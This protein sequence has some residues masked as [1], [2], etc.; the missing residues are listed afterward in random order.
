M[1]AFGPVLLTLA[2]AFYLAFELTETTVRNELDRLAI[3]QL[4][5]ETRQLREV[6]EQTKSGLE[7]LALTP[8]V[9][10]GS[11]SA[12]TPQL[13]LWAGTFPY[14]VEALYYNTVD[15]DVYGSDDSSFNVRDRYYY[16]QIQNGETVITKVI[17]SRASGEHIILVL[18]PVFSVATKERIGAMGATIQ[19]RHLLAKVSTI[20]PGF[21][22]EVLLLDEAGHP[23]LGRK[24]RS[25]G[26]VTDA[27]TISVLKSIGSEASGKKSIQLAKVKGT[28]YFQTIADT[29]WRLVFVYSDAEVFFTRRLV[30]NTLLLFLGASL[31]FILLAVFRVKKDIT[32]PM[33]ALAAS[34]ERW[35]S[36]V[37]HAPFYIQT[38]DSQGTILF[39]NQVL[40]GLDRSKVIGSSIY[41]YSGPA[42]STVMREAVAA[43]FQ[44]GKPQT[45]ELEASGPHGGKA[46]YTCTVGAIREQDRITKAVVIAYDIS[47]LKQAQE[48]LRLHSLVL[49]N[50]A[51]G[52]G[53]ADETGRIIYTNPAEERM[54]G[55]A[56]GGLLGQSVSSLAAY[57]SQD[58]K[59]RM[60]RDI[61]TELQ[62]SGRCTREV[63]NLR[64]DGSTFYSL[65]SLST[66]ELAGRR[67]IVWVREDITGRRKLEQQLLQSQKMES[68]GKLAG[69]IAHDFNNILTVIQGHAGV[70]QLFGGLH[71]EAA[72]A[73]NEIVHA[74][75][76]ASNLTRQL[77]TFS[78]QQVMQLKELDLAVIVSEMAK[79]LRRLLGEHI[80]V[81]L[82]FAPL[83]PLI[84]ADAGMIQ[85]IVMNLAVNARDAMTE[86]GTLIIRL[87][88]EQHLREVDG[89][90]AA[91]PSNFVCLSVS[92]TGRGIAP[93]H[94][95][96]IFDPFFTTKEVGKGTGLGLAT[97]YGIVKQHQGW[98][99]VESE[100]GRGTTFRVRLPALERASFTPVAVKE[101]SGQ[102]HVRG[103]E[104]ILIVEDEAPL[105][106]LVK[107][108][109][110]RFGYRV[111][112]ATSG[113]EALIL[114][115]DHK[116]DVD[117]LLTDLVMP[118]GMSGI[119]LA[120][121][122]LAEK[123][124]LKVIYTSGYSAEMSAH[125]ADLA[126]DSAFLPKPYRPQ[127]L[128]E[129][130][131]RVL[132]QD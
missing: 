63:F 119:E 12:I 60:M 13:K 65:A 33:E 21:R 28:V 77:L 74:S 32:G 93:E 10:A 38:I 40:P 99:E 36:L 30:R 22:G 80:R 116:A 11:V 7:L 31:P 110:V 55:H 112:E 130:V 1:L 15:G 132:D 35:R 115:L 97:V 70:L 89:Q 37:E 69:G 5:V 101:P 62:R 86:G 83:L 14:H 103:H 20:D 129:L 120:R 6:F 128:A 121:L 59:D 79:M 105:R 18:V 46:C 27:E 44:T 72:E 98:V 50:M 102:H 94:I 73:A 96:R 122:L 127:H 118:D 92:D 108:I 66:L 39:I 51:E 125:H 9:Q 106:S 25:P 61:E 117:L 81:H 47:T 2:L 49:E 24:R 23:I 124:G 107:H 54:F 58:E 45:I 19:I 123:P 100:P 71:S 91:V 8:N 17:E 131:R 113:K 64:K 76:R 52:V 126:P 88:V 43:V 84:K 111:I 4:D 41:D 53:L 42:A 48:E 95:S 29:Q 3:S 75:E 16:P 109:L 34:E 78:R 87:E 85:Q 67:H 82:D 56:P 90:V 68:I 57:P 114:W 26:R 104:T